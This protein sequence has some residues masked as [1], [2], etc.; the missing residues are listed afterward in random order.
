MYRTYA[1]PTSNHIALP[2][3]A[4]YLYNVHVHVQYININHKQQYIDS[5]PLL[6][7]SVSHQKCWSICTWL[8]LIHRAG[9]DESQAQHL[10]YWSANHIWLALNIRSFL[11]L[12][13]LPWP[14]SCEMRWHFV[15]VLP[16]S[17]GWIIISCPFTLIFIFLT[18]IFTLTSRLNDHVFAMERARSCIKCFLIYI[19][20][21]IRLLLE[22]IVTCVQVV[23]IA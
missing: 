13:H 4:T 14:V 15:L 1:R 6:F 7:R 19:Y 16:I 3:H 5:L 9:R 18:D 10:A 22:F 8:E 12:I 2:P 23:K 21:C 11:L 17:P 20:L